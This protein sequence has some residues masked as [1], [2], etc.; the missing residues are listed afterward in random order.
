MIEGLEYLHGKG[1]V[2]KDIKPSNLLLTKDEILKITD[3]G[4]AEVCTTCQYSRLLWIHEYDI[5]CADCYAS[6]CEYVNS[7]PQSV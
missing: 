7:R 2:H 4:V 6:F 1:I 5:L 3:L